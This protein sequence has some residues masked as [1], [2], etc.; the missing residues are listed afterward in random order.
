MGIYMLYR[1]WHD[2]RHHGSNHSHQH[3]HNH[4]IPVQAGWRSLIALGIS[5]GMVPCPSAIALMLIAISINRVIWGLSLVG[6][7]SLG[8]AS[9][10]VMLGLIAVSATNV[11]KKIDVDGRIWRL[12][13]IISASVVMVVGMVILIA[14]IKAI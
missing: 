3:T 10:L 9:V 8:L 7:F 4:K 12:I 14:G 5:G 1:R 11:V 2:F 6:A 13:P